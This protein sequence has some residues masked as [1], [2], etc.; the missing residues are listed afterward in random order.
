MSDKEISVDNPELPPTS[1][2]QHQW[3]LGEAINLIIGAG[4][5]IAPGNIWRLARSPGHALIFWIVGGL[6]KLYSFFAW[7]LS[8]KGQSDSNSFPRN[9]VY[10]FAF[11]YKLFKFLFGFATV[12]I[13]IPG[14]II[15]N[16]FIASKYLLYAIQGEDGQ[17][18]SNYG[19][20]FGVAYFDK[21]F[22]AIRFLAVAILGIITAYHMFTIRNKYV[23][24]SICLNQILVVFKVVSLLAFAFIGIFKANDSAFIP[25][26]KN[27][28]RQM[29]NST[30]FN[31]YTS[32]AEHF[33]SYGNAMLQVLYSYEGWNHLSYSSEELE[34]TG[35]Y[36][37]Y[38][39]LARVCFSF[40]LYILVNIAFIL[41]VDPKLV[42]DPQNANESIAIDYGI[43][44]YGEFG[45]KYM[46]YLIAI[47]SFSSMDS[48]VLL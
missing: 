17:E 24:Y 29:F 1:Q 27:N 13:I 28:W 37:K 41:L 4:I 22:V 42:A 32:S 48:M 36:R 19:K 34:I 40:V 8:E 33:G 6:I 11:D 35:V 23:N 39:V 26:I 12:N 9:A 14:A 21:E 46:S 25:T 30:I 18:F 3:K 44:L 16:S 47:S 45:R 20:D 7:R 43:R 15:A 31:N 2:P 38:S 10:G 5:F